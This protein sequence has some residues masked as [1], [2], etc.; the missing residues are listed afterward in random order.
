MMQHRAMNGRKLGYRPMMEAELQEGDR[1]RAYAEQERAHSAM[2]ARK[3]IVA[4]ASGN[5]KGFDKHARWIVATCKSGIEQQV[6]EELR[7][8]GIE[9]WCPLEKIR[10]RPRR[11]LK[12]VD[13]FRPYFKG[14]VFVRV[15]PDGE[16]FVGLLSASRLNGLMGRDGRPFL[17][18]EKLMDALMLSAKKSKHDHDDERAL[19]VRKGQQVV[20]RSGPFSD[21]QATIRRVMGTR[22]KLMAEVELF[23]RMTALELDI[24]SVEPC[25]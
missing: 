9:A 20:I 21:F 1:H 11:S 4:M 7:E 3:R 6:F 5:R 18:P 22:W 17:M 14:Y 8:Q 23:G 15:I 10:A 12:A 2:G 13:I 24:D 25:S 19:P 16:A